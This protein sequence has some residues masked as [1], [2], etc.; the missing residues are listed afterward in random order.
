MAGKI[1]IS[2][3]NGGKGK[4]MKIRFSIREK[5]YADVEFEID[6]E[7]Q[8]EVEEAL[9]TIGENVSADDL[10]SGLMNIFGSENVKSC[11]INCVNSVCPD[12]EYEFW[13]W[14]NEEEE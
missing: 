5:L 9:D 4:E 13:D 7:S 2:K 6:C 1:N 11:G 3:K 12:D 10:E 8:E 14:L